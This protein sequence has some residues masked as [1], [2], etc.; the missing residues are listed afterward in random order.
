MI[1]ITEDE[2]DDAKLALQR[3][4]NRIKFKEKS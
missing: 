3:A 4:V 1:E 2:K